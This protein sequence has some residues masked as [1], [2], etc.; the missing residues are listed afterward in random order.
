LKSNLYG[1]HLIDE[2]VVGKSAVTNFFVDRALAGEPLTVYEPGTQARNFVHVKD[3]ASAY[4]R[5]AE[6]LLGQLER[7]ETGAET[8]EIAG[9]EDLSVISVAE[10]VLDAASELLETDVDIK[11]VENPRG[12]E[13]M[14]EEFSV[15]ISK[16]KETIGWEP[17][18]TV[19]D[20]VRWLLQRKA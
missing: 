19:A 17:T 18:E 12:G 2:T 4:V 8:Y 15:D 1:E 14:V 7:G 10:I 5:S 20:S 16:A 9:K 11:L 3:V 13:T 6:R